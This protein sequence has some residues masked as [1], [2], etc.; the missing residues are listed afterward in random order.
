MHFKFPLYFS[1]L[2]IPFWAVID[3][4]LLQKKILLLL[5]EKYLIFSN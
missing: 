5:L 4:L 1:T 3:W 2:T